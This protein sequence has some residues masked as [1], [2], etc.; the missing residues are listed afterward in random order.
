MI[1]LRV[2]RYAIGR[3]CPSRRVGRHAIGLITRLNNGRWRFFGEFR[4]GSFVLG[5]AVH[6]VWVIVEENESLACRTPDAFFYLNF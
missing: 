3:Q 6:V 5:V 2:G 1:S 4:E